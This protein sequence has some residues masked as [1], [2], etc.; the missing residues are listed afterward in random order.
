MNPT[1]KSFIGIPWKDKGRTRAGVDC[2]GLTLLW[3]KEQMGIEIQPPEYD[4]NTCAAK[5]LQ[6]D[7]KHDDLQ[8]GDVV[9]FQ[10]RRSGK[11]RH[12]AVFLGN[13]KYLH[14][15]KGVDSRIENGLTLLRRVGLVPAGAISPKETERLC[16]ALAD[17]AIGDPGTLILIAV[18]IILAVVSYLLQPSLSGFKSKQGR[19]SDSGLITQKN[20]EIPLPDLLGTAVVAGNSVYQQLPDKSTAVDDSPPRKWNQI[21]VLASGPSELIDYETGL[22]INGLN[23]RDKLFHNADGIEGIFANPEQ[24]KAEA[25]TGSIDG[26]TNVPSV[27]IYHGA[28]GITVPVDVRAQYD[29]NF[30]VYG[31]SGCSY[32]AFRL[33]NGGKF[34]N[35]NVTCRVKCRKCRTFD[36]DGFIATTVT[37]E[38]HTG[39]GS[40]VRFKLAYEDIKEVTAL[41]VGGTSYTQMSASNQ[42]GNVYHLNATKG[43]VEFL[44][45]PAGAAAILVTYKYYPREWSQ[46]P[47]MQLVYLLTEPVRGK[48][49]DESKVDFPA[50]V[51]LRDYCDDSVTWQGPDG[52]VTSARYT[53]NYAIDDR[54]PIQDHLRAVLDACNGVMFLSNGKFYMVARKDGSSVFSFDESNV[55]ADSFEAELVDRSQ[56]PNRLKLLFHSEETLGAETEVVVD[57]ELNQSDRAARVGNNGVVDE[58]LKLPAVNTASQAQRLAETAAREQVNGNYICRFKTNIQALALQP[59]DLIDITHSAMPGFSAKVLRVDTLDYDEND[60]LLITASEHVAS[61]FL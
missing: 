8:R 55:I 9:F 6:P 59:C 39:D 54:K 40:A 29:R 10:E 2:V 20:P 30:P 41:T 56:K 26:A 42:S 17:T 60:R 22:L 19:Y 50:A 61:A 23:Y 57:D 38:S 28:Y 31:L 16:A 4:G 3:L 21:V 47:A 14:I 53:S 1:D 5:L 18:A 36:E 13:D 49:L 24:N 51:E 48:G 33:I 12:V 52:A 32:L 43:Y 44:T 37:A 46:N 58:N 45:A 34:S 35:F 27:T 15:I 7:F 11:V 25:V